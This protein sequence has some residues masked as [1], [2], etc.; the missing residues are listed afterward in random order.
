[1]A[2]IIKIKAMYLVTYLAEESEN[3]VSFPLGT[4]FLLSKVPLIFF[5]QMPLNS[6]SLKYLPY[7]TANLDYSYILHFGPFI[8]AS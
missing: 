6:F 5:K 4:L 7:I 1:M 8:L 2:V 3:S